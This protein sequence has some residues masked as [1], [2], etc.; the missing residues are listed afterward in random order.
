[1]IHLSLFIDSFKKMGRYTVIDR[2]EM[3]INRAQLCLFSNCL[4]VG[5]FSDSIYQSVSP[6]LC[7]VITTPCHHVFSCFC[8]CNC[9]VLPAVWHNKGQRFQQQQ[10]EG[11][12]ILR[13]KHTRAS[14]RRSPAEQ[15]GAS[16]NLFSQHQ[17]LFSNIYSKP[18]RLTFF[19]GAQKKKISRIPSNHLYFSTMKLNGDQRLS[20]SKKD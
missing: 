20:S 15:G 9:L 16:V 1:M 12:T 2:G 8:S 4:R 5:C 18:V 3:E 7:R 17:T 13:E 14:Q 19:S 6:E 11:K 10:R